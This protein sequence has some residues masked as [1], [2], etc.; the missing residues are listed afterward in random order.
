M[1]YIIGVER[2]FN[3]FTSINTFICA[4]IVLC[5]LYALA[6][7]G[8]GD[9]KLLLLVCLAVDFQVIVH[10][11]VFIC[12]IFACASIMVLLEFLLS[13]RIRREIALAPS[14]FMATALYLGARSSGFLQEYAHALVNSW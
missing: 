8:M 4:I 11:W 10:L 14:I 12:A 6:G 9:I 1:L 2:T 5:L 13:G 7:I 3:G